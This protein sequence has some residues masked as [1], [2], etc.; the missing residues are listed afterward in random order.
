MSGICI[1]GALGKDSDFE[2]G[3]ETDQVR[4]DSE[5]A[6]GDEE[7]LRENQPMAIR[8]LFAAAGADAEP[9]SV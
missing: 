8:S 3:L 7:S 5:A 2:V 1:R 6:D 9:S 4:Y